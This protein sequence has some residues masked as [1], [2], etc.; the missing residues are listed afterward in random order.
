[1]ASLKDSCIAH[2]K[3]NDN[4]ASNVVVDETGDNNGVYHGTGGADDYTSA[5]SVTGIISTA[6]EF[7]GTDDYVAVAD[8][9]SLDV[10]AISTAGWLYL[11]EAPVA[12]DY[13]LA[14]SEDSGN[15]DSYRIWVDN[16][17]KLN[18]MISDTGES[19]TSEKM[20]DAISLNERHFVAF[21][22]ETGTYKIYVNGEL[23]TSDGSGAATGD[24]FQ[25]TGRLVIGARYDASEVTYK[26]FFDG[27]IDSVM[28]FN[29]ALTQEEITFLYNGGFGTEHLDFPQYRI[30]EDWSW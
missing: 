6:L 28:I 25:G 9:N 8:S 19:L 10:T 30:P 14:K 1:M 24:I 27:L 3:M 26:L 21:T 11:H 13:F 20:D 2:W 15:Q 23:M 4:V 17:R 5:H 12:G 18:F 16:A 29:K 22:Y 7:D